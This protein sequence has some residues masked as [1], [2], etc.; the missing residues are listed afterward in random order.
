MGYNIVKDQVP[1]W[2]FLSTISKK[3]N[4]RLKGITKEDRFKK[5]QRV[6]ETTQSNSYNSSTVVQELI[7]KLFAQ[8]VS[9]VSLFA[10]FIF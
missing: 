2:S 1:Q 8:K 4:L 7:F 5:M 6:K 3:E 10:P 9:L